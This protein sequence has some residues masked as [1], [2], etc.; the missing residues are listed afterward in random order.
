MILEGDRD[1]IRLPPPFALTMWLGGRDGPAGPRIFN[2][3]WPWSAEY[4][5]YGEVLVVGGRPLCPFVGCAC[6]SF[7]GGMCL[8]VHERR[9]PAA[10]FKPNRIAA[11]LPAKGLPDTARICR[12]D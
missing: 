7:P 4:A 2:A 10:L 5:V 1:R 6:L 8:P 9:Q 11:E 3:I 12:A